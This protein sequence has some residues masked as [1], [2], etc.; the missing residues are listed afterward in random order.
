MSG[1]HLGFWFINRGLLRDRRWSFYLPVNEST[2]PSVLVPGGENA[3]ASKYLEA[4]SPWVLSPH[5]QSVKGSRETIG[6]S[7]IANHFG[8]L[9]SIIQIWD[10]RLSWC[11]RSSF[12]LGTETFDRNAVKDTWG[13]WGLRASPGPRSAAKGRHWATLTRLC[14][15]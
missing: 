10:P 3:T 8:S 2:C 12:V 1:S 14:G 9:I 6:V 5:S 7:C 11:W 13:N 4:L 15:D